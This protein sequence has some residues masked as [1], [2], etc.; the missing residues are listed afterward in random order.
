METTEKIITIPQEAYSTI[1]W[2][3]YAYNDFDKMIEDRKDR[4]REDFDYYHFNYSNNAKNKNTVENCIIA[5]EEDYWIKI[6]KKW[7]KLIM[8][9]LNDV[10]NE[11]D[12][13][14]YWLVNYLFLQK[15]KYSFIKEHLNLSPREVKIEK[16]RIIYEIY[17]RA[18][19]EKL[20]K[21]VA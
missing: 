16:F 18:I 14:D 21:E 15:R 6:Y 8:K 19:K 10:D 4:L 2:A 20:I 17:Q 7:Q 13:I 1:I 11:N 9:Y 3:L 12:Y 5:L